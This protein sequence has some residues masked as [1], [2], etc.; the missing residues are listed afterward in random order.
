MPAVVGQLRDDAERFLKG[1]GFT[2]IAFVDAPSD[3]PKVQQNEVT[4]QDPPE[5][6]DVAK[7]ATITLTVSSGKPKVAVPDVHGKSV[8]EAASI[9]GQAGLNGSKTQAEASDTVPKDQVIRTDPA[10]G[11][12]VDKGS[13]VTIIVSSGPAQVTVP[14]VKSL[15]K[16]GAENAI[17]NAG[18]VPSAQCHTNAS[19]PPQGVVT[20]Q[21][22]QANS[23]A[24]K[25]S[26]VKFDVDT[27]D[28]TLCG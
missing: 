2:N 13:N 15:T 10:A 9:L 5:G 4:K 24:E 20:D 8:A 14:S 11:T 25:G 17:A 3:D 7:T 16:A 28:P 23:K 6:A 26:T 27:S 1:Q 18:L 22:P 19:A 21:N 12:Q